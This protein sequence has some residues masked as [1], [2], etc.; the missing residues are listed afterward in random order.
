MMKARTS[1]RTLVFVF[2]AAVRP[3]GSADPALA[4][5]V[6]YAAAVAEADLRVDLFL[7]GGLGKRPPFES[8]VMATMLDGVVSAERMIL[9]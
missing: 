1:E 5:R 3:D 6:G 4:R 8:A 9:D 2:G 7:S